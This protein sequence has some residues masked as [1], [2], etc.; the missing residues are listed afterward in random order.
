M[1]VR[2]PYLFEIFQLNLSQLKTPKAINSLF[3]IF[4]YLIQNTIREKWRDRG[5]Q[6]DRHT[7]KDKEKQ[8]DRDTKKEIET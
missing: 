8:T 5:G 7:D 2:S 4:F 1:L 3:Y 6:T